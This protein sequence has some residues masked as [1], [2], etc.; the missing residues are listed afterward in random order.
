MRYLVWILRLVI[1]V[2]VLLFA[3]KNTAPVDVGFFAGHGVQQVP[4]IVVMLVAFLLG[5]IFGLLVAALAMLKRRREINRLRR[6]LARAQAAAAQSLPA[7]QPMIPEV[8]APL[9]PL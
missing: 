1:F 4:L 7:A 2:I 6:E 3:L 5:L 9:A 8:A